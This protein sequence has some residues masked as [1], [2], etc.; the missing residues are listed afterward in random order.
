[1]GWLRN[2]GGRS[3][4]LVT[5][6]SDFAWLRGRL[7]G[8]ADYYA[9]LGV[10]KDAST[11]EIRRAYFQLAR[12]CHP[13]KNPDPEAKAK[14]QAI[15]NA[16]SVLSNEELRAKYDAYGV[17]GLDGIDFADGAE[18][19][20][21]IFGSEAFEPYVGELKL[22][23]AIRVQGDVEKLVE[24]QKKRVEDLGLNLK[25]I[26]KRYCVGDV[27]GF[28]HAMTAEASELSAFPYG[29]TILY[30]IGK[31]YQFQAQMALGNFF[32]GS[33][34]SIKQKG[35]SVK[36]HVGALN[37]LVKAM[38]LQKEMA[39]IEKRAEAIQDGSFGHTFESSTGQTMGGISSEEEDI[40]AMRKKFEEDVA[41]P[42]M[43]EVM[44]SINVIDIEGTLAKVCRNVLKE[45]GIS[46]SER[47]SRAEGLL[48]L[49]R[50]F[51][52]FRK[53]DQGEK[54][55]KDPKQQLEDAMISV[56]EKKMANFDK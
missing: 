5:D 48:E 1:M 53:E 21:A 23:T 34:A 8:N 16:Y 40:E 56:M 33:L 17:E 26:L 11:S 29:T 4:A 32:T 13:D 39:D 38:G 20:T 35:R 42:V 27:D 47:R 45:D 2:R 50:I 3:S 9:L 37:N 51:K 55:V 30:S 52:S 18:L 7:T 54:V 43:L 41:L 49:A 28:T 31:A 46:S 14:F 24:A 6:S 12:D 19:Y 44:W 10:S 15:S 22:A 25:I 36:T